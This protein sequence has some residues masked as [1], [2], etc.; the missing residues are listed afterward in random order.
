MIKKTTFKKNVVGNLK[1]SSIFRKMLLY[2]WVL[3]VLELKSP[4]KLLQNHPKPR[5]WEHFSK[6]TENFGKFWKFFFIINFKFFLWKWSEHGSDV[7]GAYTSTW[8]QLLEDN[9]TIY[10][11]ANS[12]YAGILRNF[13]TQTRC[14]LNRTSTHFRNPVPSSLWSGCRSASTAKN[15]AVA[16][17]RQSES[18]DK[19]V[20]TSLTHMNSS[21]KW[22]RTAV[23]EETVHLKRNST[24]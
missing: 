9:D 15:T 3:M 4:G 20:Q 8:R 10:D 11:V 12:P 24:D 13:N 5:I 21:F 18:D 19:N 22:N 6:N 14:W 1:N 7:C 16:T 17:E 23:R 2:P